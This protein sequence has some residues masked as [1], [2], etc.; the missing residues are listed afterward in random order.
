MFPGFKSPVLEDRFDNLA[1]VVARVEVSEQSV[2]TKVFIV[3]NDTLANLPEDFNAVK[4]SAVFLEDLKKAQTIWHYGE[5]R[6][7]IVLDKQEKTQEQERYE[8]LRAL[9]D[10][11]VKEA[12]KYKLEEISLE[13]VSYLTPIQQAHL[14]AGLHLTNYA[15][16]RKGLVDGEGLKTEYV[17]IKRVVIVQKDHPGFDTQAKFVMDS[18]R[19]TIF[20][21]EINNERA[22]IATTLHLVELCKKIAKKNSKISIEVI[23]GEE[24]VQKGLN[25]LYGVGK[26]SSSPPA[27]VVL[28][29][30]G[31]PTNPEDIYAVV[32]KGVC[33]DTGGYNIK[34]TGGIENMYLDKCGAGSVIGTVRGVAELDLKINLVAA[35]CL[36]ENSI[37]STAQKPLDIVRTYKGFTVEIGNTDAEGRLILCDGLSW[38]QKHYKPHTVFDICTLTGAIIVA[39]GYD[40]AGLFSNDDALVSDLRDQGKRA[41]EELWRMPISTE[42]RKLLKSKYASTNNMGA[43]GAL[44]P[45]SSV[46][47]AFLELFIEKDVK[48]A[49]IDIAGTAGITQRDY[50]N[51]PAGA[52][53][54]GTL[55]LLNYYQSKQQQ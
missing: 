41:G 53:G 32:G 22:N 37:S 15:F 33:F 19:Y 4:N 1:N 5:Q 11:I 10:K 47:A 13:H 46:A 44:Q 26:G 9:A 36:V 31:N 48:W 29:Y 23:L 55:L 6:T 14:I 8:E 18:V 17:Q 43:G 42:A 39:L 35:V 20:T 34:P 30:K 40:Y 24:L 45:G 21:R 27:L 49:H 25:S 2:G 38:V 16:E 50:P 51:R 3:N 7:L 12:N 28:N 52:T 54:W